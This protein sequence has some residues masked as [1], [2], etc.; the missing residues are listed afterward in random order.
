M[1]GCTSC[2][3]SA[4]KPLRNMPSFNGDRET[5]TGIQTEFLYVHITFLADLRLMNVQC[6]AVRLSALS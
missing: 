2:H 3:S 5:F 1:R 6:I 4:E